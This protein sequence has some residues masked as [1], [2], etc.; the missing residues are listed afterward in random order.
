MKLLFLLIL[1]LICTPIAWGQNKSKKPKVTKSTLEDVSGEALNEVL[2]DNDEVLVLFYEDN[3]SPQVKKLITTLEKFDLSD[4]GDVQFV[5][6]SDPEEAEEFGIQQNELPK[7]VLFDNSVPDEYSGDI[8]DIKSKFCFIHSAL[9]SKW[10]VSIG[11]QIELHF[12]ASQIDHV[13]SQ[14]FA[15]GQ[16]FILVAKSSLVFLIAVTFSTSQV[17]GIVPVVN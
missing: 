17:I 14:S 13:Q 10:G 1:G 16:L 3:K 11:V 12:F 2:E 8:L 9:L 15:H 5:R 4:L 6:C 7:I